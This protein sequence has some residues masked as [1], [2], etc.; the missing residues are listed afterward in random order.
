MVV[1]LKFTPQELA[2]VSVPWDAAEVVLELAP[3]TW[4]ADVAPVRASQE[5]AALAALIAA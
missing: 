3:D 1:A 4:D 2:A 5:I